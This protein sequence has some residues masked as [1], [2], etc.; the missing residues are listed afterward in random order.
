ML[1]SNSHSEALLPVP[2]LIV[3]TPPLPPAPCPP[4]L[5]EDG[6]RVVVVPPE[7]VPPAP[8]M[9]RLP[10][11]PVS[12]PPVVVLDPPTPVVLRV[13]VA[14]VAVPV[15]DAAVVLELDPVVAGPVVVSEVCPVSLD[16]VSPLAT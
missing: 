8:P 5:L 14:V 13:P 1:P 7:P 16:G 9:S 2:P 12:P 6:P 3:P 10:L 11:L 4:L 15:R